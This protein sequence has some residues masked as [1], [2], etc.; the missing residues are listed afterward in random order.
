MSNLLKDLLP[1]A[2]R[3]KSILVAAAEAGLADT[4]RQHV[5]QGM[6]PDTAIRLTAASFSATT[7]FT[8]E[9]CSWVTGEIATALG[10]SHSDP[11]GAGSGAAGGFGGTPAGFDTPGQAAPTQIAPIPGYTPGQQP[12]QD[13]AQAPG[14]GGFGTGGAPTTPRPWQPGQPPQPGQPGQPGQPAQPGQQAGGFGQPQPG[15]YGQPPAGAW[16]GQPQQAGFGQGQPVGGFG[17]PGAG[18]WQPGGPAVP[19][20][21]VGYPPAGYQPGAPTG[22][23]G[24][25]V[26]GAPG[27]PIKPRGRGR[28]LWIAGGVVGVGV[29][30]IIA[31][32]TLS[33]GSK[34]KP[35]TSPTPPPTTA[36]VTSTPSASPTAAHPPGTE[37]LVTIMNPAGQTPVG[38]DCSSAKLFGLDA[39]TL[40]ASTFCFRSHNTPNVEVWGYQFNSF[41]HYEAG[42]KHINTFVGFN[43]TTAGGN[44]PPLSGSTQG[45][46][47]WHAIHNPRYFRRSGQDIECLTDQNKP[48]VIW[49]MPTQDAFFIGQDRIDGTTLTTLLAWWKKLSYG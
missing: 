6:D 12:T 26:P 49:T 47:G 15:G 8:S 3:E 2:P 34:P 37:A 1:D 29:V 36:P 30:A 24:P 5:A 20:A 21:P 14:R 25:I 31:A 39:S 19:V 40:D 22:P 9:A 17:Q 4:L 27:G 42:L 18:G 41:A 23:M 13:A 33:S 38:T 44:C 11:V 35:T 46:V 43:A 45:R 28:G 48:V 7:P 10:M 16:Q 32:T